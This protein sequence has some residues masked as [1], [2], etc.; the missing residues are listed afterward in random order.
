VKC[1]VRGLISTW[2]FW[3]PV[4]HHNLGKVCS[5]MSRHWKW[6]DQKWRHYWKW[7][8]RK[9]RVSRIHTCNTINILIGHQLFNDIF[10]KN[11]E[12]FYYIVSD[13]NGEMYQRSY[14]VINRWASLMDDQQLVKFINISCFP[15]TWRHFPRIMF[16]YFY[17][18]KSFSSQNL[19]FTS[20]IIFLI[21][22]F[23]P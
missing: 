21:F 13:K 14:S 23:G 22:I 5:R 3:G 11:L 12:M 7:R 17:K 9:W 20:F 16:P 19:F 1:N 10:H 2:L 8:Q 4:G 15:R 6:R 18:K